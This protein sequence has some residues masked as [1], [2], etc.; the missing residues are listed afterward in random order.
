M[1]YR[2]EAYAL[3]CDRRELRRSDEHVFVEPQVFDILVY[4]I[5]NRERVVGKGELLAAVWNGR[6]VSE[7]TFTTRISA[8]R[9][10]IED[11][12]E[13]QR[14]IRTVTRRGLRF[15]G[16]VWEE[17]DARIADAFV[18]ARHSEIEVLAPDLRRVPKTSASPDKPA[19]AVVPFANLSGDPDQEYVA[20]GISEDLVTALSQFRWLSVIAPNSGFACNGNAVNAK[21]PAQALGVR[22]SLEG[23]LR[24]SANRVRVTA[25]LIDT[26]T[27]AHLWA[28]RCDAELEEIFELQDLVTTGVIAALAPKLEQHEIDRVKRMSD[29]PDPYHCYLRGMGNVYEWSRDGISNALSLFHRAIEIDPEFATAYGMAAYCYVQR[30]SYG[31][32]VDR[33]Q[34]VAECARLARLAAEFGKDDAV[35]L[36]KAAHAIASVVGDIDS[37][38][39]FIEQALRLNPNLAAGWYVSGWIKLFLGEPST[40]IEHLARAMRL[41]PF[42]QLRVKIHAAVAY[43]HLLAGRYD[44]ASVAAENA[45]RARSNYL[46]AM[47]GASASHALAGRLGEARKLIAHV[48]QGDPALHISNLANLL[49]FRRAQDFNRW[50]EGLQ[51]AGLPD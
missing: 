21:S 18:R 14:L 47:R 30:T 8:V 20:A 9:R 35:A 32:T 34:E 45:L 29:E 25:R 42:D 48:R 44:D 12:G 7:S 6:F 16:D 28:G 17:R 23:S 49:P 33:P 4:L 37:G 50:A 1:I 24:K 38:A 43:A 27:F 5:R 26:A 36:S 15:V 46:T 11:S 22:Y 19:I 31:W 41:S 39:I 51:K 10:A 40:A 13:Q 2:F 3:D